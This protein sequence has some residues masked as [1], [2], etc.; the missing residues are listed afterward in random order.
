MV[1]SVNNQ[2]VNQFGAIN[3]IGNAQDGRGVYSVLDGNGREA[4]KLSVA[5]NDCDV[6]E[7]S[8]KDVMESAPKIQKY[9][10]THSS[11]EAIQ[12][13]KRTSRWITVACAAIGAG[14]PIH[15]TRNKSTWV[16]IP[17]TILGMLAG[18]MAGFGLSFAV[19]TP[20]GTMKFSKA[21]K[22]I[23]KIDVQPYNE[24]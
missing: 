24:L 14:I 22:N 4:G 20:P 15:L 5:A 19:T 18:V 1:Q 7:K 3:R 9:V 17:V 10:Q 12:K 21:T 8:Y 2:S 6:F 23:S 16:Q 13:R 11:P